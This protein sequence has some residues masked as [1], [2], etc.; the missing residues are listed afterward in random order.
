MFFFNVGALLRALF[1]GMNA[2]IFPCMTHIY[3]YKHTNDRFNGMNEYKRM[4][5]NYESNR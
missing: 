2:F 4:D 5:Q 1:S 3:L